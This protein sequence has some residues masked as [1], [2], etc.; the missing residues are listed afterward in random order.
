LLLSEQR[1]GHT[2]S[3]FFWFGEKKTKPDWLAG[4]GIS[5]D[6]KKMGLEGLSWSR[7]VCGKNKTINRI[8]N[9]TV[10]KFR[11]RK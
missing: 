6:F 10:T 2:F 4:R 1:R 8:H 5:D 3:I 11:G 7:R 9:K